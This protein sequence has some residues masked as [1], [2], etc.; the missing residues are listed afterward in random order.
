MHLQINKI[1]IVYYDFFS[2]WYHGQ[3]NW[4]FF[5]INYK[6]E[7]EEELDTKA[8]NTEENSSI[9]KSIIPDKKEEEETEIQNHERINTDKTDEEN[10]IN[11]N[12]S[13][14]VQKEQEGKLDTKT[15]IIEENDSISKSKL[16]EENEEKNHDHSNFNTDSII[17]DDYENNNFGSN[18]QENLDSI[19]KHQSLFLR[20]LVKISDEKPL[21]Y[22]EIPKEFIEIFTLQ[23]VLQALNL[24]ITNLPAIEWS[25]VE[26]Y[27]D[28][29][30]FS[31]YKNLA[32]GIH[33]NFNSDFERLYAIWLSK[34][35]VN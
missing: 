15:N 18:Y 17:L 26:N 29:N 1:E 33:D 20:W 27:I 22:K 9:S 31:N 8:N 12:K 2:N 34:E 24:S 35:N 21:S 10:H 4:N 30:S 3:L 32:E 25:K 19:R 23:G 6:K 16:P 11:D 14:S 5:S 13:I 7:Q 28:N